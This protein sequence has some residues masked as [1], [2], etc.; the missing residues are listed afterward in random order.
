MLQKTQEFKCIVSK[1]DRII[2]TKTNDNVVRIFIDIKTI[3]GL[4]WL[5][6]KAI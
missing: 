1:R 5:K 6:I 4:I 3:K 2:A